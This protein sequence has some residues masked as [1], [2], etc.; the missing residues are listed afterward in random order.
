M[1]G[2][3]LF[4]NDNDT[5]IENYLDNLNR[6]LSSIT[7]SERFDFISDVKNQIYDLKEENPRLSIDNIL[8]SIGKPS[9]LAE[10]ILEKYDS[11]ADIISKKEHKNQFITELKK[12]IKSLFSKNTK[13]IIG[14]KK[15]IT[16]SFHIN[17]LHSISYGLSENIT[18]I[19][20]NE[21]R[22][23]IET[24]ENIISAINHKELTDGLL[25]I[26]SWEEIKPTNFHITLYTS[27]LKTVINR[28]SGNIIIN[29]S[30]DHDETNINI[31]SC[32][33]IVYKTPIRSKSLLANIIG[34]GDLIAETENQIQFVD[35]NAIGSGDLHILIDAK[36]AKIAIF[37]S[38]D[39]TLS[40]YCDFLK[41]VLSGSG[42]VRADG[43]KSKKA[44]VKIAGSG[45]VDLACEDTLEVE[46]LGSGDVGYSGQP[47]VNYQLLGSGDLYNKHPR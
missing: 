29:S 12:S 27:E 21:S 43:L 5:A 42:D 4:Q 41:I 6:Y 14:S 11:E 39:I 23:E 17:K 2:D 3:A 36:K 1:K 10:K 19:R 15:I 28:G 46:I 26:D 37:G 34:S 47:K 35:I 20:D 18:I 8:N 33:N 24:D 40:G 16:K 31:R 25:L 32:G 30:F 44:D 38:S 13:A 7:I 22:L 45:D 9:G